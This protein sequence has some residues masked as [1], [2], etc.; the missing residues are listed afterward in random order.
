MIC[1]LGVALDV[2]MTDLKWLRWTGIWH[3]RDN[4]VMRIRI[5]GG[6]GGGVGWKHE[7]MRFPGRPR[8]R[9]KANN[10]VA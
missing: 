5:R 10:E 8:H 9:W 3:A 7:E 1:V 4:T 2:R 6:E